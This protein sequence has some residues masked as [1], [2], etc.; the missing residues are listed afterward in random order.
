LQ[1]AATLNE[2]VGQSRFAM[3]DMGNDRK[4]SDVIHQGVATSV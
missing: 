3:V 2:P 4:I 1:A